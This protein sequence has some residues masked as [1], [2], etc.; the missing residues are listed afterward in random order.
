MANFYFMSKYKRVLGLDLGVGS[1][2]WAYVK[3]TQTENDISEIVDLGVRIITY[4]NFSKSDK[5]KVSESKNPVDEFI[6]GKS[7]TPNAKRT[8]KRGA[9]RSFQRYKLRRKNLIEMLK[10][11]HLY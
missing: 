11:H 4:D 3:K 8:N 7:V 5:G 9:R 6:A 1:I 10:I 2:G